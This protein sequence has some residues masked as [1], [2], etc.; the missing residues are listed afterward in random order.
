MNRLLLVPLALAALT[1]VVSGCGGAEP[2]SQ[3]A[4]LGC[5]AKWRD[6]WQKL[7]DRIDAAVYCPRWLPGPLTAEIGGP[8]TSINAVDRDRSYLISFIYKEKSEE[9]HVNFR[10]YPGRPA[11]P[12]CIDTQVGAGKPRRRRIPCFS[13]PGGEKRV[14][15]IRAT[16]YTVNQD[17]DQWHVLYAWRRNGS[18]YTLSEHV[19]P[20]FSYSR[21]IENLDRMLRNL[22]LVEPRG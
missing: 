16:V 10:G 21:V 11:I 17:A 14:A 22:V 6:G 12:T 4:G 13:D 7:A 2:A 1:A 5:P 9:I 8:W 15:G 3:A 20:P 18:L 19:A